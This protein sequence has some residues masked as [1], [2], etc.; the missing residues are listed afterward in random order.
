MRNNPFQQ[1]VD[2][3]I[4]T[5]DPVKLVQLLYRG[6]AEAVGEAR[7]AL[8]GGQIKERAEAIS[9]TIEI[10]AELTTALDHEKGGKVSA[11]LA[12]LYDYMQRRLLDAN[13]EQ[14]DAPLAEVERLLGTLSEAWDNVQAPQSGR[15]IPPPAVNA[16]ADPDNFGDA[17]NLDEN[18]EYVSLSLAC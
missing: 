1:Y 6:A 2:N 5:A 3:E 4:L 17:A 12:A 8:A 13:H 18:E 10:L 15:P 16:F 14:S 11:N 9:K 7:A